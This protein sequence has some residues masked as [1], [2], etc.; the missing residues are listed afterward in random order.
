MH[1]VD[2]A[3]VLP[4]HGPLVRLVLVRHLGR[5]GDRPVVLFEPPG[6]A[7]HVAPVLD[8]LVHVGRRQL[9]DVLHQEEEQD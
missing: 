9:A 1:D 4:V 3:D 8:H 6:Q 2:L 7:A 5:D